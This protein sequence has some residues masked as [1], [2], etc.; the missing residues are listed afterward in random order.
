MFLV[1]VSRPAVVLW[2]IGL[3]VFFI[4]LVLLLFVDGG[5]PIFV[6]DDEGRTTVLFEL[7]DLL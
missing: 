6:V 2:M 5:A 1:R 7:D 4:H 3:V